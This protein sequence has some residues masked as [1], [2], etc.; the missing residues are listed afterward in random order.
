MAK[1]TFTTGQVLLASQL[2]SLQQTAMLGGAASAKTASYT[3][4]AADAGTAIS[5]TSTSATTVTV[6]TGLFAAGDTVFIQNLGSGNLTITAGT[7]TVATAGSLILPQNDAGILYFVSTSSSVFY[8]FIQVGAASPLTTKGDLYTF[9]TSDTRLAVGT[10]GQV[11]TADSSE[12]T[13]LKFA[14]PASGGMTL[15][16]SGGTTLTGASVTISS[17]PGTYKNLQIVV[18]NYKPASDAQSLV[19]NVNGDTTANR[20]TQFQSTPTANGSFDA[21][22]WSLGRYA[23]NSVSQGLSITTIYN[24]ANATTWKIG[25][26]LSIVNDSTTSTNFNQINSLGLYN[27]TGAVTSLRFTPESGNFTSGTIYVYGVS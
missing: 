8:D 13:G 10:N 24:Y 16:N 4:V 15:I 17:I 14:T 12:A 2:T 23:D 3:L 5:M 25:E 22:N 18:E 27:Q 9:S 20:H 19:M 11:L 1:Q 7:A 6:N 26:L 21:T